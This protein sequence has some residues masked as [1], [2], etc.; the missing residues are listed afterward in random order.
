VIIPHKCIL[1]RY[2]KRWWWWW[3]RRWWWRRFRR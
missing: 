1:H 3:R 2:C